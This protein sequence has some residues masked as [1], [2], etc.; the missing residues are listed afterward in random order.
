MIRPLFLIIFISSLSIVQAKINRNQT[1]FS[2]KPHIIIG[3]GS[4]GG[5]YYKTGKYIASRYNK[6]F[7]DI[8]FSSIETNGSLE[9]IELLKNNQI[10][11]AI[12]QRNVLLNSLYD[13]E[14]GLKNLSVILPLFQ[15]KLHF[16]SNFGKALPLNK[17]VLLQLLWIKI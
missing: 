12:V 17:L 3:S 4:R 1:D 11:I 6:K 15:E 5:N 9:N 7:P 2:G 13:E 8:H 10:D 14:N 16:Y